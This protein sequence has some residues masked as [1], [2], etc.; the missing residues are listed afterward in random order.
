VSGA[1]GNPQI[2]VVRQSNNTVVAT[3]DDWGTDPNASQLYVAG[4]A[5]SHPLESGLYITLA[6]GAYTTIVS[7]VDGAT[8]V[9]LIEVYEVDHPEVALINISTRANV[10]TGFNV[11]IGGFVIQGSGT[12]TVVIRALGPSLA[13]YGV[14]GALSN[15]KMDLVRISDNTTIATNDDWQSAP[16]AAQIQSSGFAPAHPLESAIMMT[17]PPGSIPRSC[18]G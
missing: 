17:L 8:G 12:Q 9:G 16:N 7:G 13:N 14:S 10:Q 15:P 18:P 1:I 3:N 5:P 2:Q 4:Y 6:P 11:M